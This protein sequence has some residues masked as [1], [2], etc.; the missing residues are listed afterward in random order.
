MRRLAGIVLIIAL[1][2][3]VL[4]LAG[5][6]HA[7]TPVTGILTVDTTWTKAGSPYSLS[8]PLAVNQGVTLTIQAGTTVFLNGYYI[9][10]NGTLTAKGTLTDQ[11]QFSNGILRFTP[12]SNG[13]NNGAGAG[14]IIEY[15]NLVLASIDSSVAL[16]LNHNLLNASVSAGNSSILTNNTV[17]LKMKAGDSCTFS[18]NNLQGGVEAG[19]HC[20]F[21]NNLIESFGIV[22]G[23]SC[24]I[25]GN[26]IANDAFCSGDSSTVTNNRIDGSV[27]GAALVS[28][29]IITGG[30]FVNGKVISNNNIIGRVNTFGQSEVTGNTIK[31]GGYSVQT[32]LVGKL[33][34]RY[35]LTTYYGAVNIG[36]GSPVISNNMIDGGIM[37]NV[38]GSSPKIFNNTIVTEG[39]PGIAVGSAPISNENY[40]LSATV[41]G[42]PIIYN[43][44]VSGIFVYADA[45]NITQNTDSGGIE[46]YGQ[47]ALIYR[48][49]IT[50][51]ISCNAQNTLI[52]GNTVSGIDYVVNNGNLVISHNTIK[53]G[54]GIKGQNGG[55]IEHNYIANNA[56]GI[57]VMS[58][59]ATIQN[60]TLT[61]N[62]FGLEIYR[63]ASSSF[64]H[65]NNFQS[66]SESV[67]LKPE[68][69][70]NVSATF[71]WWG[72]T[73]TSLIN[74]AIHDFNDDFNLGKVDF[75]PF[76][77]EENSQAMPDTNV[78]MPT[79]DLT[80]LSPT[81]LASPTPASSSTPAPSSTNLPNQTPPSETQQPTP[82]QSNDP[83]FPINIDTILIAVI[84][85]LLVAIG[86]MVFKYMARKQRQLPPP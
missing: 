53:N 24:T 3:N 46:F 20:T 80:V 57:I 30:G 5:N 10:V 38:T 71:N 12:V 48:N 15:A 69:V 77:T 39:K 18:G 68:N 58:G 29:N 23:E 41:G 83:Q 45:C 73:D 74:Q 64:I 4:I 63:D 31:G 34:F 11:I 43:N 28:N 44:K 84:V 13:W 76:L 78:P 49:T 17:V 1:L 50:G 26:T 6:V 14:C 47:K 66:S 72:T 75:A 25:T 56:A 16:K 40:D 22:A 67:Y 36:E 52:Y 82:T 42:T 27:S 51:V 2:G 9:Q 59:S 33:P 85:I 19:A 86:L 8:G 60:N 32:D 79:F 37:D 55:T 62:N 35:A 70:N 7:E 61:G 54:P 21:S 65:Y 81:P